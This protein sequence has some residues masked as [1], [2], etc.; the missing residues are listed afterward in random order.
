MKKPQD[1]MMRHVNNTERL[2]AFRVVEGG[3]TRKP[4]LELITNRTRSA[5]IWFLFCIVLVSV[6]WWLGMGS[7]LGFIWDY[8]FKR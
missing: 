1:P 2:K 4:R 7:M 5:L 8:L 6:P 3:K